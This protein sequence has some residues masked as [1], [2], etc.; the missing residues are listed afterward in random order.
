M[1]ASVLAI[2]GG[3]LLSR[4]IAK[5]IQKINDAIFPYEKSREAKRVEHTARLNMELE[6]VR[7]QGRLT[8]LGIQAS[9]NEKQQMTMRETNIIVSQ[10]TSYTHIKEELY[11]DAIKRF[12]L[13]ISPLSL[14]DNN[15]INIDYFVKGIKTKTLTDD[16][17][18]AFKSYLHQD[19]RP[20]NIFVTP[21]TIDSRVVGKE[22]LAAQVWDSVYQSLESIFINEYNAA[23]QH[24][25][26]M[27]SAA[28][29]HNAKPGLHAAEELY[30]FLKHIPTI[31]V[32]PRFDGK[33]LRIVFS[34]W[35]IGYNLEQRVRQ[36]IAIEL[37]WIPI[38][39]NNAYKR[40]KDSL[41]LLS[42]I[43]TS[44]DSLLAKKKEFCEHN[45][46]LYER[47]DIAKRI[48]NGSLGDLDVLG[49]YSRWFALDSFDWSA[50]SEKISHAIG[51]IIAAV[52]DTHHLLASDIE[53]ILPQIYNTYFA[54][55]LDEGMGCTLLEMYENAY[56]RLVM[57]DP[58]N[59]GVKQ[60]RKLQ[61]ANIERELPIKE[62]LLGDE[63]PLSIL[64]ERCNTRWNFKTSDFNQA[65]E[66]YVNHFTEEDKEFN[67][68]L[69]PYLSEEQTRQIQRKYMKLNK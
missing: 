48:Q 36:E 66:Y 2:T 35:S 22:T 38:I 67:D 18:N 37:D 54:D 55:I 6:R 25:A 16:Q 30:F 5:G 33:K 15:N 23:S 39:I 53:P 27:F 57:L 28:W 31:V 12:P 42:K 8:E 44:G 32:E 52:T 10:F 1:S 61:L 69:M 46:K 41:N 50:I 21:I 64:L 51:L 49:D 68:Q 63:S 17:L 65:F 58:H 62:S 3:M 29:N 7:Q 34:C 59:T 20:L 24:P 11:R 9:M 13:N 26:N 14:L 47:L 40:A 4:G 56:D 60:L 19:I 45:V 43:D